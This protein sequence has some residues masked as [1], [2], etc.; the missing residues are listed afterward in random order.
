MSMVRRSGILGASAIVALALGLRLPYVRYPVLNLDETIYAT[1]AREILHGAVPYRDVWEIKPPLVFYV[2]A[3]LFRLFGASSLTT[4][5]IFGA[6]CVALTSLVVADVARR[7]WGGAAGMLAGLGVAAYSTAARIAE[8][9]AAETELF[10]IL[11]MCLGLWYFLRASDGSGYRDVFLSG[12]FIGMAAMFKQPAAGIVILMGAWI[13]VFPPQGRHRLKSFAF[14]AAGAIITPAAFAVYFLAKGA[15]ADAFKLAVVNNFLYMGERSR[16]DILRVM[17]VS[18]CQ[19]ARPNIVLWALSFGA[20]AVATGRAAMDMGNENRR[21][22]L[23]MALFL[24]F[25]AVATFSGVRVNGHYY[26][27]MVPALALM[28]SLG[29]LDLWRV[30]KSKTLRA[31]LAAVLLLGFAYPLYY[32]HIHERNWFLDH[33][34]LPNEEFS[35]VGADVKSMTKPSDR[36]FVWGLNPEIYFWADRRPASRFI[37]TTFQV[38]LVVNTPSGATGKDSGYAMPQSWKM[39]M[40]DLETRKPRLF[41]D[42]ARAASANS[43]FSRYPVERYPVLMQFL[44]MN[45]M[46]EYTFD[47]YRT[48]VRKE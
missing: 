36:I 33:Q 6:L 47:G 16:G 14:F 12:L 28:W 29:A 26:L 43:L 44:N 10:L 37:Y 42:A 21:R 30:L 45:Y 27:I 19:I 48:F 4:V 11:P 1:I 22:D 35:K 2:Y 34:V 3:I 24:I 38:G 17:A 8:V 25:S 39:L 13:L 7:Q 41:I 18:G 31:L 32:F 20:L 40:Q 46:L 9:Q 5:H 23:F 15:L